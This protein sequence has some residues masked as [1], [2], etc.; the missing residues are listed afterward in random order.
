VPP[1]L[2]WDSPQPIAKQGAKWYGVA[3]HLKNFLFAFVS[4]FFAVDALGVLPLFVGLTEGMDPR[5]RKRVIWQSVVTALVVAVG[6]VLF[7]RA[8][9]G[10]MRVT[11]PDFMV[12]GGVLLFLIATADLLN[13]GA[14]TRQIDPEVGAV[15]LGT[16]LIVGPAVLTTSLMLLDQYGWAET[17]LAVVAN[18]LL[19]GVVLMCSAGFT[20][21]L[22]RAGSRVTS[23]LANLLLAA[24]AVMMVRRGLT[25]IAA[26]MFPGGR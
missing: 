19:A 23:K 24:I 9:L 10:W 20:R 2:A 8:V 12:A 16:P 18:I 22:G 21:V 13:R 17:L 5:T 15:P 4:L 6:F 14:A 1:G 7:G 11:V 26:E 3:M 25:A